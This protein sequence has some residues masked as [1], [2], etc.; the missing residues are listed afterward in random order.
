MLQLNGY[1][2]LTLREI[3]HLFS[4]LYIFSILYLCLEYPSLPSSLYFLGR[5]RLPT[6]VPLP[7]CPCLQAGYNRRIPALQTLSV[8]PLRHLTWTILS[9]WQ[10]VRSVISCTSLQDPK[11]REPCFIHVPNYILCIEGRLQIFENI[12][13]K[14]VWV[15]FNNAS[16]PNLYLIW[17]FYFDSLS[18]LSP[19]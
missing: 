17:F 9:S 1:Y 6:S 11:G 19:S 8:Q 2:F 7:L 5:P 10:C 16:F 15:D 13:E 18:V 3:H 12:R 14:E 4:C